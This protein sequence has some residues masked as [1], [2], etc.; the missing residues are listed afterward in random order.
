MPR[1]CS[2]IYWCSF[3]GC[4]KS[5]PRSTPITEEPT[6]LLPPS[7]GSSVKI[8]TIEMFQKLKKKKKSAHTKN[9]FC[10][11]FK[12]LS[13]F[14]DPY[15]SKL[16]ILKNKFKKSFILRNVPQTCRRHKKKKIQAWGDQPTYNNSIVYLRYIVFKFE[17]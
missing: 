8:K 16:F 3:I 12:T 10:G 4:Y 13:D 14:T 15:W 1:C 2:C 5:K 9:F 6:Q 17:S 7:L 11:Q